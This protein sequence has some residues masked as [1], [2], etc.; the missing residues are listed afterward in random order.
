MLVMVISLLAALVPAR[1]QDTV[2]EGQSS[3]ISVIEIPGDTYIWDLYDN[4]TG[5]N[6][7]TDPGNCDPARAWFVG[8]NTGPT[9]TI[10]WEIHG[11]Y[12]VRI[13]ANR[14]TCTS[15]LRVAKVFV[16]PLPTA[17]IRP[18]DPICYG[19]SAH[20]TVDLTGVP[21]WRIT[22][23]DGTNSWVFDNINSTPFNLTVPVIPLTNTTYWIS[24]VKDKYITNTRPSPQ[25]I[26][27]VKPLPVN[28]KIYQYGP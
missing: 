1:A 16:K 9:V 4:A 11:I 15:N 8:G 6:F 25:V 23:T 24:E 21:P 22:L 3:V 10:H 27:V 2:Y 14:G 18:P 26:Q 7:A 13:F 20:L 19:D 12:F 17:T 5:V 28:S